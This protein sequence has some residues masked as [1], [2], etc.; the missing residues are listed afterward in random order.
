MV[1]QLSLKDF[2]TGLA[3]NPQFC[4]RYKSRKR[5]EFPLVF[6]EVL[7]GHAE[8]HREG[9]AAKNISPEIYCLPRREPLCRSFMW[10]RRSKSS[11]MKAGASRTRRSPKVTAANQNRTIIKTL[12]SNTK[13][14]ASEHALCMCERPLPAAVHTAWGGCGTQQMHTP[15]VCFHSLAE[16]T[17]TTVTWLQQSSA[18]TQSMSFC[19]FHQCCGCRMTDRLLAQSAVYCRA[20]DFNGGGFPPTA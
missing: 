14:T 3:G 17:E 1:E 7:G 4:V 8:L 11:C 9:G 5:S 13:V 19:I 10:R 16:Q 20:G 12:F 15:V 6:R 2:P 18:D